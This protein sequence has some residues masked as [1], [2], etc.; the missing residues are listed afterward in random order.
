MTAIERT[1]Y[2]CAG[3]L[4]DRDTLHRYYELSAADGTFLRRHARGDAGRLLLA[5]MLK[6]RVHLGFFPAPCDVVRPVVDHLAEQLGAG[7]VADGVT[8]VA[9]TKSF[10]RYQDAVRLRLGARVFGVAGRALVT[11][12][13]RVAAE[14]M[15]DPAD[16]INRA[17]EA[18]IEA[19]VDL[20][21]FSTLD[22]LVGHVRAATHDA[23][24]R[25][26]AARLDAVDRAAL[27]GLLR[28]EERETTTPFNQLKQA[29]GT[30]THKTLRHWI[31]RL[32]RLDALP[33]DAGPL[34]GVA[35]TKI[36]QFAAEAATMEVDGLRD[37]T[38]TA[39][40][41]T[42][43]LAFLRHTRMTTRD[44]LIEMLVRRVRRTRTGAREAFETL[45]LEHRQL[46][47]TLIGMLGEVA[48][49]A[50]TP[51]DDAAFGASV[52]AILAARGG[53]ETVAERVRAVAAWHADN[54][55][56]LLW[57]IHKRHRT[58]LFRILDHLEIRS[59]TQDET[60][61]AAWRE[62]SARRNAKRKDVPVA[63][64][65]GF[66]SQRWRSFVAPDIGGGTVIDRRALEV[67]VFIHITDAL[68]SGDLYV[69][70]SERF[71]DYRA[72]LMP[73]SACAPK[74]AAYCAAVGLPVDGTKAVAALKAEL[75][76]VADA[77]DAGFPD[78]S[79]LSIDPDGTPHLR[80]LPK[81]TPPAG[82]DAFETALRAQMP[83]RHLLDV[84]KRAE[85]WSRFTRH[86]GPP[87]GADPK[88]ARPRPRYLFTVFGYGCNLGPSQTARHAPD[89]ISA[90]AMRRINAQHISA[91]RL[92]KAMVD[93]IDA[94]AR[95][96]LPRHWGPGRAA[97]ADGTHAPLRENNLIGSRHIRYGGYG[98]IAYHHIADSYVA[99]FTTAIPCGVW[100][101]VH[102]LDGLLQNESC[103]QPDTLHADT[104][105]QS[106][107]VFGLSR[108]LGIQ[109][110][111][112]IRGLGDAVFHRPDRAARYHH[113]D[114]L[115]SAE[116]DWTLIATHWR[117]ML[118]VVLSIQAGSVIPSMLLRKL[119]SF[120][121]QNRLYRA[122]RE[123][124]RVQRTIFLLRYLG[125]IELR[126]SIRAETTKIETFNDFLDW[127]GF[128]GPII[129]SG[130][131]VEQEKSL[132]Y[133]SL[134]AN[135]IMLSNVVDISAAIAT[136]AENGETVTPELVAALSPYMREH[137][138]RFGQYVLDMEDIPDPLDPRP[139]PFDQTL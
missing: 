4:P 69:V 98:A 22:R 70:G 83:E 64:D 82:L 116:V 51:L 139:L 105:G 115:F 57:P 36:R 14:T 21:A 5:V 24:Y 134:V 137:I 136:M 121:R 71:A 66:A 67:C 94:Y 112:R 2:P 108:L 38:R 122:F 90:Q 13:V 42:L 110:M 33:G 35:H 84:L 97:I 53:A 107:P 96:P 80:Q 23:L 1:A 132:K 76:A 30:P 3:R 79:A 19:R 20:P 75:A 15:S 39:R 47:E 117:D 32:D 102:I 40:R 85:H 113:I 18:L 44:E 104:Q 118:Q 128:G 58:L 99:L 111:P 61:L 37:V 9:R 41:H 28:R 95:F 6:T 100:E 78:N 45:R 129:R 130:D 60:L 138:R 54:D 124:G 91:A 133:A 135:A 77:L 62:V 56:P 103:V 120:N 27:E 26:V 7:A 50:E 48:E 123:L 17:I 101:A 8:G 127:I 11:Q 25:K 89:L 73:W 131:P 10:Y 106:A 109:L 49:Q 125:D 46:E 34:E 81:A 74:A 31:E 92:E 68:L 119:G 29:P 65:L 12:T 126:R 55:L 52:R 59:A 63:L 88:L 16:L 72:Q 93:L 86:F 43:L 114:P 87:S